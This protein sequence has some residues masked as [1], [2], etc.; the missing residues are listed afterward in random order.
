MISIF[1]TLKIC[2]LI[3][4]CFKILFSPSKSS[5]ILF[6]L[7]VRPENSASCDQLSRHATKKLL[8]FVHATSLMS[9]MGRFAPHLGHDN[10]VCD[11]YYVVCDQHIHQRFALEQCVSTL[12]RAL[13]CLA[14]SAAQQAQ[15]CVLHTIVCPP[16]TYQCSKQFVPHYF[17]H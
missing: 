3:K 9:K 2:K 5:P 6:F 16:H 13:R 17:P 4:I 7:V 10:V 15:Q 8:F 14:S 11:Q 1:T 12:L